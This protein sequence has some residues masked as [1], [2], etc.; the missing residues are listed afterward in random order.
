M[1][2]RCCNIPCAMRTGQQTNSMSW[3]WRLFE[4]LG[5]TGCTA[6]A[7]WYYVSDAAPCKVPEHSALHYVSQTQR[8]WYEDCYSIRVPLA[9]LPK[10]SPVRQT[11]DFIRA[12]FRTW[13]MAAERR[14]TAGLGYKSMPDDAILE[15]DFDTNDQGGE[16]RVLIRNTGDVLFD[17]FDSF[18]FSWL[19]LLWH[20]DSQELE[21]LFGSALTGAG[22]RGIPLQNYLMYQLA[23]PFHRFYSQLLLSQ[24]AKVLLLDARRQRFVL[25]QGF[26]LF[27]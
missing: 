26:W 4:A 12:F 3:K 15:S 2:R 7:G 10:R 17:A 24:A 8:V 23:M 18:A 13:P 11:D 5:V 6:I 21:L 22:Y 27:Q 14:L 20:P 9:D 19:G 16:F 1:S 25:L